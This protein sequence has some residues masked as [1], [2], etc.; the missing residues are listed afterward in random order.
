MKRE[1]ASKSCRW[2]YD[3]MLKRFKRIGSAK[4]L[5]AIS[6]QHANVEPRVITLLALCK[7]LQPAQQNISIQ[8][9]YKMRSSFRASRI[10]TSQDDDAVTYNNYS[11]SESEASVNENRRSNGRKRNVSESELT[12]HAFNKDDDFDLELP[13]SKTDP[14]PKKPM[15]RTKKSAKVSSDKKSKIKAKE[16]GAFLPTQK[17]SSTE[18]SSLESVEL[19]AESNDSNGESKPKAGLFEEVKRKIS[20][21]FD[22]SFTKI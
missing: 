18:D 6:K 20:F 21:N 7:E 17:V 13:L 22:S 16:T 4:A 1:V 11:S 15:S 19:T 5:R 12:Y 14:Y 3:K 2:Y 10:A 8:A 9:T